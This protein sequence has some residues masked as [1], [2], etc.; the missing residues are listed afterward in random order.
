[1]PLL[2]WITRI[3]KVN[4]PNIKMTLK[5]KTYSLMFMK[6]KSINLT[7]TIKR[8]KQIYP[9]SSKTF[10]CK[11][12]LTNITKH[13]SLMT[14]V[15][16]P[17]KGHRTKNSRPDKLIKRKRKLKQSCSRINKFAKRRPSKKPK[18]KSRP[19]SI[20]ELFRT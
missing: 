8:N 16:I 14:T 11:V 2:K 9:K 1:M 12:K 4:Y 17:L 6:L 19:M 10:L 18:N 5:R 20:R 3:D 13:C 15:S 7:S